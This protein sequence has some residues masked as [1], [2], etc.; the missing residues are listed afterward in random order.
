MKRLFQGAFMRSVRTRLT[1]Y[2]NI[3]ALLLLSPVAG[4]QPKEE[5]P[6]PKT[7]P[8]M[9][10]AMKAVLDEAHLPGAGV[11]LVSNGELLWCGRIGKADVAS[12]RDVTCDT[13]FR[14]GSISKSFV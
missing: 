8:D 2:L 7:L 3:A 11:A 6:H 1:V 5:L 9:Q 14:V 13:E 10:K 4:A 12:G